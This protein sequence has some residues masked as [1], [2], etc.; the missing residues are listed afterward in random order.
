M[1]FLFSETFLTGIVLLAGLIDDLRS[2]KI[3]NK[4]IIALTA[5]ILTFILITK[6]FYGLL[7]AL[8]G[9]AAALVI[10]L[11]LNLMKVIGGGDLKL[12]MAAGLT[13]SAYETALVFLYAMPWALLLGLGK[14]AFD[15][16]FKTFGENLMSIALLQKPDPKKLHAIPFSASLFFGWLSLLTLKSI[17]FS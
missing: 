14:M 13:M 10:C 16:S 5:V 4:L 9:F 7:A 2:R 17:S 1:Q 8:P 11:P 6:G 3:H 15:K 12:F